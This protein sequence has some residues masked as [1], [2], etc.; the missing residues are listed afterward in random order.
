MN[1]KKNQL[2]IIS[3]YNILNINLKRKKKTNLNKRPFLQTI[4]KHISRDSTRQGLTSNDGGKNVVPCDLPP[5]TLVATRPGNVHASID[6]HRYW[7]G[8]PRFIYCE[9]WR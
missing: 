5:V 1:T 8:L 4:P 9:K 6:D 2:V 7:I 3:T